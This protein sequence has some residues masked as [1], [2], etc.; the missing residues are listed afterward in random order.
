MEKIYKAKLKKVVQ[1]WYALAEF[2]QE[3]YPENSAGTS[4]VESGDITLEEI[5]LS[6]NAGEFEKLLQSVD[7]EQ[8]L[9]SPKDLPVS[10]FHPSKACTQSLITKVPKKAMQF[11]CVQRAVETQESKAKRNKAV[12][13]RYNRHKYMDNKQYSE[14]D[15][16]VPYR[17]MLLQLR[18]YEPFKYKVGRALGHPKF[19]QEYYVLSSQYLT[20]LKDKILCKCDDGPYYDISNT[21]AQPNEQDAQPMPK[22]GFFFIHDTFYNDLREE[23]NYDYSEVVRKWAERQQMIGELRSARMED[24]RFGDLKFR[25]GYPQ[26]YQHQG[27]CEHIFVV[28]DCR[29]LTPS[30]VL[31]SARYPILNSFSFP[32]DVP[33]NICGHTEAQFILKNSNRH[34]FDPAYICGA[35]LESYHYKDGQKIGEFELYKFSGT[36]F[37]LKD[38]E[39]ALSDSN[40]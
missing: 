33:C 36:K 14:L 8:H 1:V 2:Q 26:L 4:K 11:N 28:S 23:S 9:A 10:T 7:I 39:T 15:D 34:I 19:S 22:S 38:D 31:S 30:D 6:V 35:C 20:A 18:F 32:R 16:L 24:T 13:L 21:G 12:K 5:G 3:L 17:E 40:E 37:T 25:I 27:N 29:L